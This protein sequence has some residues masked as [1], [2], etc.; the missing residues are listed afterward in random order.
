MDGFDK[1]SEYYDLFYRDKDYEA[2]CDFIEAV[3][4][5]YS[6]Q[7]VQAVLDIG[8]GTGGHAIPLNSRGHHV[9]GIDASEAMLKKAQRKAADAGAALLLYK[10][11]MR[12]F[13]LDQQF[14]A[15]IAMFAVMNYL[16][17]TDDILKTLRNV[18]RHLRKDSLFL[19]DFWNGLAVLRLLPEAREMTYEDKGLSV[20]RTVQPELDAMNHLCR[21][22]YHL[23]VTRDGHAPNTIRETH[24][25][26]FFFPQEI[27]HYLEDCGF[28]LLTICP[29]TRLE[30]PAD[31]NT[32]NVVAV[33]QACKGDDQ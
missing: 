16:T 28:K 15:C 8:C 25:I 18:R 29:F 17:E 3:F 31:E 11:D 21:V 30:E 10:M 26:R 32:W 4:R 14:D 12:N 19:F 6:P 9:T 2:E 5:R 23:S 33:A 27:A 7:Q 24:V 13:I 22:N 20:T 1:Y